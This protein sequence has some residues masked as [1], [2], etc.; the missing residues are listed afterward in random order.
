MLIVKAGA[1]EIMGHFGVRGRV[2]GRGER[3]VGV[4]GLCAPASDRN[5]W[6]SQVIIGHHR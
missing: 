5:H 1:R 4:S 3:S 6:S 2:G